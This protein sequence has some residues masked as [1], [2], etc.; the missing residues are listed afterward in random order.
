MESSNALFFSM[1]E[2]KINLCILSY[3]GMS[4]DFPYELCSPG[5]NRFVSK[6]TQN[7]LANSAF[8]LL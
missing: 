1:A 6:W 8:M 5:V 4:H 7:H 2:G 3:N